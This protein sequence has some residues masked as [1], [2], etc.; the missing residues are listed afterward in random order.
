[1]RVLVTGAGGN[2]GRAVVSLC[3]SL[4]D[5][6]VGLS[7][8]P[9]DLPVARLVVGSAGDPAAVADALGDGVDAVVH[10]AARPSP[11]HG[12]PLEVFGDNTR[13]TFVVLEEAARRGVRHLA[14][15]G[16]Y[17]MF[18]TAFSPH[19]A[20]PPYYPLDEGAPLQIADPYAL[21][22]QVDEATGAMVARRY[23]VAVVS[24]RFPYTTGWDQLRRMAGAVRADPAVMAHDSWSYL[25]VEDA[26]VAARLAVTVPGEGFHAVLLA[27][28]ETLAPW[29]TEELI[30]R[31]HPDTPIRGPIP[32]RNTPIDTTA[33]TALLGFRPT[34]LLEI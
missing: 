5:E 33:A 24:L 26:A 4:G 2:I 9:A 7:L 12:T 18:G 31:Y 32:G 22:K 14:F 20:H 34:R 23:G 15:A 19:G 10:L 17:A 30:R 6:V 29:P 8:E 25:H 28:P 13:A 1:M 27:A 16:S 3:G 11:D 21:S